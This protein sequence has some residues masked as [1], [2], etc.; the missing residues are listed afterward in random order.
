MVR[1]RSEQEALVNCGEP[2]PMPPTGHKVVCT[3]STGV[4]S[5]N[6]C[7]APPLLLWRTCTVSWIPRAGAFLL[8]VESLYTHAASAATSVSAQNS[9]FW[10]LPVV[11]GWSALAL[12]AA[13]LSPILVSAASSRPAVYFRACGLLHRG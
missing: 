1:M 11:A 5:Y 8:C 13:N 2:K 6:Q 12:L 9:S 7:N 4:C 3:T 10:S